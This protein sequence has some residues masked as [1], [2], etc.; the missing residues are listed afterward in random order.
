MVSAPLL[1]ATPCA[2]NPTPVCALSS[3]I[4]A[5]KVNR[6]PNRATHLVRRNRFGRHRD[7][8]R[9]HRP[10]ASMAPPTPTNSAAWPT[11]DTVTQRGAASANP[12]I[13]IVWQTPRCITYYY[14]CGEGGGGW[15]WRMRSLALR[16]R[17]LAVISASVGSMG[18]FVPMKNDLVA[19]RSRKA[20]L[21]RR[22][23][24]E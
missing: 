13:T 19:A 6:R 16:A 18:F 24:S 7:A 2:A 15:R 20:Y 23:S 12:E 5:R 21:T 1:A 14:C 4:A 9:R 17:G 10:S 3:G 8:G 11:H 22:S